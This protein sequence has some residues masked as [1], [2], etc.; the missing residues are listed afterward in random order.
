MIEQTL[1]PIAPPR[2]DTR[3][4]EG[5]EGLRARVLV[6]SAVLTAAAA[7]LALTALAGWVLAMPALTSVLPGLPTFKA[8][9]A[10][11]LLLT[12]I[13]VWIHR[14]PH[15]PGWQISL[16]KSCVIGAMG[17]AVLTALEHL[18]GWDLRI[19][20][21]LVTDPTPGLA[22]GR[23]ALAT[24][25]C[26]VL[27][28]GSVLMA[29]RPNGFRWTALPIGGAILLAT[30]SIVSSIASV[31]PGAGLPYGSMAL[32]GATAVLLLAVAM[33][34]AHPE[35]GVMEVAADAGAGG[36][37]VRQLLPVVF[38]LPLLLAWT[39]W[40]G[41]RAGLYDASFGLA[42]VV[43][44]L[45]G[46]LSYGVY[47]CGRL[48][49]R[50]EHVHA[51]GTADRA[52]N[53]E[54]LRRA[55]AEAPA[56]I[57]IHDGNQIL[58]MSRGW[59]EAAGYS[60]ADTPTLTAWIAHTHPIPGQASTAALAR[61]SQPSAA[62]EQ[63]IR[64]RTG[65]DRIWEFSTTAIDTAGSEAMFVTLAADVTARKQAEADLR[66]VNESLEQRIA[67]RTAEL[68]RAN[69]ALKRQSDRLKEQATLLDLVRD[70]ILVRD[71]YGTIVYWS[72]G[73]A[74][75]YGWEKDKALGAVSHNL[76][77]A[78]YPRPLKEIEAQ[79]LQ[80]GF[81]EGEVIHTTRTGTRLFV[82]S[83]WTLT[84]T[85]RGEPEG[86]LE[87]NRDVTARRRAQDSLRDSELRFRAVAETAI[88]GIVSLDTSGLIH[89]WNPGAERLFGLRASEVIGQPITVAMP[90]PFLRAFESAATGAGLGTTFETVG[91]HRGGRHFPL[92]T[93]VAAWSNTQGEK[94]FTAIVRDITERKNAERAIEAKAEELVRSNQELEQF[95]YV[96]SHD[97]QE[98]LRMVSNY[99]Q[100]LARRYKDRLDADANEFI[101]FAVDGAKRMQDLIHDLLQYARVGTRGREFKP[102]PAQDLVNEAVANL[103][104]AIEE[105]AARVTV[106]PLP[107]L[108]CDGPQVVQVFQNLIGNA[109]KFRRPGTTPEVHVSA[110]KADG[111]WT[112]AVRDNGIGIDGKH[113]ER[114][115]QMFQRLHA[116]ADYPG[117]GIGLA[118]CRKIVERHG[119]RIRVESEPGQGACFLFSIPEPLPPTSEVR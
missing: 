118:L 112:I 54:R 23:M 14:Q 45:A 37:L 38:F 59:S 39:V 75:M 65:E 82:E 115:F 19:D 5:D 33:W 72:R 35:E 27:L 51:G 11:A 26:I 61:L 113:F 100:L 15:A 21:V 114:I 79:V 74:D 13:G 78:A 84:R 18:A 108:T 68:T 50:V 8:N 76:L 16:L 97:L 107:V 67:E 98:P 93:S 29:E 91:R 62:N 106:A 105:S 109:V 47:A 57:V 77:Q 20:Q 110:A 3:P 12:S 102:V 56:P 55:V 81:W 9:A 32:H 117:T 69:D 36:V 30:L 31:D 4:G 49:R 119:G 104:Q 88:E 17:I 83:R 95:A 116:R 24:A 64:T 10:V 28:N 63:P 6:A 1:A 7:G 58:H 99:T 111:M 48:L 89:Y 80:A 43:T 60:L 2:E 85:D 103:H 53:E 52:H 94:F 96:A 101:D 87:V 66:R 46:M 86:F 90:E 41:V 44:L 73:A 71:L 70:G 34:C 92:E 40:L 25:A 22:P 42:I